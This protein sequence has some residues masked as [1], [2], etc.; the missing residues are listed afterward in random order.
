MKSRNKIRLI[1][2]QV[3]GLIIFIDA[4]IIFVATHFDEMKLFVQRLLG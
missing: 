3:A 2:Y 1:K 4:I